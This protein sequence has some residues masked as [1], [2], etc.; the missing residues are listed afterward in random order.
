MDTVAV[1]R[2][3]QTASRQTVNSEKRDQ[4]A[5]AVCGGGAGLVRG[6]RQ[7]AG[8]PINCSR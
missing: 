8:V 5:V 3:T 4:A 7:W 6:A 2:L 1:P